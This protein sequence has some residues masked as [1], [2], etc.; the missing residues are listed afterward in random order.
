MKN[1]L[2]LRTSILVLSGLCFIGCATTADV[3]VEL[4][5]QTP[6]KSN[7]RIF[8]SSNTELKAVALKVMED[9][10]IKVNNIEET[11]SGIKIIGKKGMS[12]MSS[13]EF[14]GIAIK[15]ATAPSSSVVSVLSKKVVSTQVFAKNWTSDILDGLSAKARYEKDAANN[16]KYDVQAPNEDWLNSIS[17]A[18]TTALAFE[19]KPA[20][21]VKC[22]GRFG[23]YI[24]SKI[25][26]H[27]GRHNNK[28]E[29]V[30]VGEEL[31]AIV[32]QQGLQMTG[33]FDEKTAVATGKLAGAKYLLVGSPYIKAA[34]NV[35]ELH[36]KLV[37]IETAKFLGGGLIVNFPLKDL[38]SL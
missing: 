34:A 14:V 35:V 28:I 37:N 22:E 36:C 24:S 18:M 12:L 10:G 4:D 27:L 29:L 13:G 6:D 16:E 26:S 9:Y 2:N 17:K 20:L 1:N 3:K 15:P 21:G 30:A 7:T 5:S 23:E 19:T 31:T 38:P 11:A 33:L 32:E 25:V 8:N